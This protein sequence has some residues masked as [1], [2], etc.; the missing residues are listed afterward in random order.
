MALY[1]LSPWRVTYAQGQ[2][3]PARLRK[4]VSCILS[5]PLYHRTH[6]VGCWMLPK[7]SSGLEARSDYPCLALNPSETGCCEHGQGQ[8]VSSQDDIDSHLLR[9]FLIKKDVASV[10][11]RKTLV[12]PMAYSGGTSWKVT[13]TLMRA[14]TQ[15]L[16]VSGFAPF[17]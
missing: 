5:L 11:L 14:T 17:C 13:G 3:W 16:A 8:G 9:K 10:I 12:M 2:L 7:T 15:D 6:W 1:L 4:I